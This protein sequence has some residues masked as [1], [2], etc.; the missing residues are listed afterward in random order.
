MKL[1]NKESKVLKR[2]DTRNRRVINGTLV[3]FL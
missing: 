1:K 3:Q 2:T